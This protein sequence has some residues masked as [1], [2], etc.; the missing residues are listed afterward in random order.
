[1]PARIDDVVTCDATLLTLLRSRAIRTRVLIKSAFDP[2]R[3]VET[4]P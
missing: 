4:L 3:T 1:M 2:K